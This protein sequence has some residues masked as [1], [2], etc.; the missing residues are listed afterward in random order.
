MPQEQRLRMWEEL[1]R[2][3]APLEVLE[4][5]HSFD[6]MHDGE[7]GLVLQEV[8]PERL[9]SLRV[10]Y[11][12]YMWGLTDLGIHA[13]AAAGCGQHLTSLHLEGECLVVNFPLSLPSLSMLALCLRP[14]VA[15]DF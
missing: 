7:L 8:L 15:A 4:L 6:S 2:Y 12:G 14:L 3:D 1:G 5:G 11:L 9:D 13:L 10:L